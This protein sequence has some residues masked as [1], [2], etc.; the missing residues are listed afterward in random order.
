MGATVVS[1]LPHAIEARL[2]ELA[3]AEYSGVVE[4]HYS[5]GNLMVAKIPRPPEVITVDVGTRKSTN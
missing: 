2:V 3:L 4:L 1:L 5:N